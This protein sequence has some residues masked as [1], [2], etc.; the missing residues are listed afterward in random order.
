MGS[1]REKSNNA[2]A[3]LDKWR[4]W[5]YPIGPFKK[6]KD[7]SFWKVYDKPDMKKLVLKEPPEQAGLPEPELSK[8]RLLKQGFQN[9]KKSHLE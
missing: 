7:N 2:I 8:Y 6:N 5:T 4:I 1:N 9:K 3:I